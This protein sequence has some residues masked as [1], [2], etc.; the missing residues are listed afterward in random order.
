MDI[1]EGSEILHTYGDLSDA[2]LLSIYG[3]IDQMPPGMTNPHNEVTA[4][5]N[6]EI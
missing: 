3:F 4:I 2:E 6:F 5:T 1:A